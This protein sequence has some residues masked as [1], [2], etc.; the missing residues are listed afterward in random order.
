MDSLANYASDGD[1]SNNSDDAKVSNRNER[2]KRISDRLDVFSSS[3]LQTPRSSDVYRFNMAP[4]CA[5]I[6]QILFRNLCKLV[7][8]TRVVHSEE[9]FSIPLRLHISRDTKLILS[10]IYRLYD[11]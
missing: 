7:L 10:N 5:L 6:Q 4:L 11:A 8:E 1:N 3:L 2:L 9:R